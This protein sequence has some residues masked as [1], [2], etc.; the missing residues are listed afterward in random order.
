MIE[1]SVNPGHSGLVTTELTKSI[2]I[3]SAGAKNT[4]ILDEQLST[5]VTVT[6]Y[7]PGPILLIE[8]PL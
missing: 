4:G 7:C 3:P 1:P 6:R 5:A 2:S 8:L